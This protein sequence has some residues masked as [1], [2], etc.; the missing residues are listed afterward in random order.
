[1]GIYVT[2]IKCKQGF[3]VIPK[4][5]GLRVIPILLRD[6]MYNVIPG[7]GLVFHVIPEI[8]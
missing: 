3:H 5:W 8:F 7:T 2:G 1:M 4:I 6:Y